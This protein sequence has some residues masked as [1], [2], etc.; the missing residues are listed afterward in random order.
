MLFLI[1]NLL[2]SVL[3]KMFLRLRRFEGIN[4]LPK[5]THPSAFINE[6]SS[7][8]MHIYLFERVP[9]P[10]KMSMTMFY[11][12]HHLSVLSG[13]PTCALLRNSLGTRPL[14]L[15]PLTAL[16]HPTL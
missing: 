10:Q 7:T 16:E 12:F 15:Q 4:T 1:Q 8:S 5:S 3:V 6:I 2:C 9:I 11:N 14:V 13:P